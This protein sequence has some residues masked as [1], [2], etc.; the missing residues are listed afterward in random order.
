[1]EYAVCLQSIVP[2]RAEASDRSE[3]VSQLLFGEWVEIT[4]D[5]NGWLKIKIA[6]DGYAGWVNGKQITPIDNGS[7]D[8]LNNGGLDLVA[9]PIAIL[10][11]PNGLKTLVV[12]G[13]SLPGMQN[14]RLTLAGKTFHFEGYAVKWKD[15]CSRSLITD[16]SLMYE[17]VPYMWGG[18]TPFGMDCSGFTQMVYR[19]S[20]IAL[21]RDAWQQALQ[22]QSRTFVSEAGPGDL[23]FF[24]DG[25]GRIIHTGIVLPQGKI[26]HASG[27]VRIDTLDHQ[28]IFN[29]DTRT[30]SHTLRLVKCYLD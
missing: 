5:L 18:R 10:R 8:R 1:M 4:D 28:G 19:L 15:H 20:G 23:A 7:Y 13:S 9:E 11:E 14:H 25:E 29:H 3:M 12:A 2:V 21:P 17:G 30:Y 6:Y 22:G 27:S 24:D 26:I 16:F